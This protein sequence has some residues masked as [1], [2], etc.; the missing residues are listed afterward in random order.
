[1]CGCWF[2]LPLC[3]SLLS[4]VHP[5]L[6]QSS[7]SGD[8]PVGLLAL[9]P[10]AWAFAASPSGTLVPALA[11]MARTHADPLLCCYPSSDGGLAGL[12]LLL[13]VGPGLL[14]S[15]VLPSTLVLAMAENG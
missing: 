13:P 14:R 5:C 12:R 3:S 2:S 4:Y 9:A 15:L 10:A 7:C 11:T 8:G 1:M 6:S